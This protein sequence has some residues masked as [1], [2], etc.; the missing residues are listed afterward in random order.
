MTY[1]I[2][3]PISFTS[4]ILSDASIGK[5]LLAGLVRGL[6]FGTPIALAS[7]GMMKVNRTYSDHESKYSKPTGKTKH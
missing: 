2:A 7:L 5:A 4:A 3:F 1:A 6:I